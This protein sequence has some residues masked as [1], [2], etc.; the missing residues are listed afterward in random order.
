MAFKYEKIVCKMALFSF[1]FKKKLLKMSVIVFFVWGY[2]C[3]LGWTSSLISLSL[4]KEIRRLVDWEIKHVANHRV[5][6]KFVNMSYLELRRVVFFCLAIYNF[7][8]Y[9]KEN[10][11]ISPQTTH[12]NRSDLN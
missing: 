1:F 4:Y 5:Y 11:K 2:I 10:I 9:Q 8:T 7:I 6:Q 12:S 3:D